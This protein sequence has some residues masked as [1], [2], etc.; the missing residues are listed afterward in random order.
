ML[1]MIIMIV[2]TFNTKFTVLIIKICCLMLLL[3][4]CLL[5]FLMR[6]LL[7][8]MM[9]TKN[10]RWSSCSCF[11]LLIMNFLITEWKEG[12]MHGVN[13]DPLLFSFLHNNEDGKDTYDDDFKL[14]YE[15]DWPL[16]KRESTRRKKRRGGKR[17]EEV[18]LWEEWSFLFAL[19][20]WTRR[21][22]TKCKRE[23]L[24]ELLNV[25]RTCII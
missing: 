5:M 24:R 23:M 3:I 6:I 22:F 13:K 18:T 7:M 16:V 25:Q 20:V 11:S 12:V 21:S 8:L 19:Q 17:G 4:N 10:K 14:R 9:I 1:L 2:N 15:A